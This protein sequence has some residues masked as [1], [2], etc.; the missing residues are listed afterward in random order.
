[1]DVKTPQTNKILKEELMLQDTDFINNDNNFYGNISEDGLHINQGGAK[2]F[3]Q[4][5]RKYVE[6][7]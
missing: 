1:M 3:A 2:R 7:W 6:Y 5:V 4:N